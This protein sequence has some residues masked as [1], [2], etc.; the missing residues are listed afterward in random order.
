LLAGGNKEDV[1]LGTSLEQHRSSVKALIV[2]FT[3][4]MATLAVLNVRSQANSH[5]MTDGVRW[6]FSGGHLVADE[7][8]P[9][10]SG[11][12]AGIVSGDA[13]R[14]IDFRP[15]LLPQDVGKI[16][17]ESR[18]GARP[19]QYE[20]ARGTESFVRLVTPIEKSSR[21]YFYLAFVGFV[22]LA[23][24][25]FAFLKS[26][27]RSFA[28]HFYFLCL[29]FFGTYAFSSTGKL[30]FLDWIFYWADEVFLLALA[31]VF[32]HFALYFPERQDWIPRSKAIFLYIPSVLLLAAKLVF[33]LVYYFWPQTTLIATVEGYL[34]FENIE[35]SYLFICLFVGVIVLFL[36]YARVEEIIH[37]KQLKMVLAGILA[38]FGP[39]CFLWLVSLGV[40]LPQQALE[41]ALMSQILIP[42]SLAY[43]LLRYRLMD[44]DILIKRGMIYTVTT[45][46][47]FVMYLLLTVS[48]LRW[49]LPQASRANITAIASL[50]TLLAALLFQPLRDRVRALVDRFY[51]RDSYDYRRT[52]VRFSREIT[53][54]LDLEQMAG[55]TLS[56]IRSTFKVDRADLLLKVGLNTFESFVDRTKRI[57]PGIAVLT[58]LSKEHSLFIDSLHSLEEE[59][60][61]DEELL[62]ELNFNYFVPCKFQQNIVAILALTKREKGDYL[63]SEDLDLLLTLANQL[64]IVIENHHL[65]YSLKNKADELERLKNFNENILLSLNVGILTLDEKGKVVACNHWV[66]S[67]LG[68]NRVMIL[69][70]SLEELFP[71]QIVDRYRNY[72]LKS[73]RKKLEG[74][75]FYKTLVENVQNKEL[76]L[77]LSFVPLIN[78]SDMEYG[79]ILILDDVTHQAKLEEQLT[80]SEKLSALGLLAAGV[81]HEVNTPLTGISSYTQMLHQQINK[82]AD[83]LDILQKIEQQ[84][85]RASKIINTLLDLSRQQPQPFAQIDINVLMRE[86]LVLLKPHFKDLPI[87]IVQE[88]DPT[89]PVILGNE[90]KLQQVFTNLLLNAKEAMQTIGGRLLARTETE[91][92]YVIINIVDTGEGIPEKDLNRI[93][94]P[95]FT[96]KKGTVTQG[97][98]LGLAITYTIIQE[99][100]G[101]IDV[102][103]EEN[104]GT[105][106]QIR[107]PKV[108]REVHEQTRAYTGD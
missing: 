7:V 33:T 81:A 107:L 25:L 27:S 31:P 86:T 32:L 99:H 84:T 57:H 56:H 73:P 41:F 44:V 5:L 59:L 42:L 103:S 90:G 98:G 67:M 36:S 71:A 63:S 2:F 78:E 38:G 20:I 66:E 23:I 10:S 64:A 6:V 87:E 85:F 105:H 106:F 93:Y 55:S 24:G 16:I 54:S 104:K 1:R 77:N 53:S 29:A 50:T 89:N 70:R 18:D 75:R 80:Q 96:T 92:E 72:S 49:I 108:K 34:A 4:V 79:T 43:A 97:T 83:T 14:S 45:L 37:K 76:V 8:L 95:F 46:V 35:L 30:D 40:R 22:I 100:R 47:L 65:F 19:L 68:T 82:D 101:S 13:L 51:Y 3:L 88:W 39:F 28:L 61:D 60:L 74:T 48:F 69:G 52:L 15:V 26:R 21:F 9:D 12:R 11:S 62:R 102:F 91:G 94:E 17:N 58:R